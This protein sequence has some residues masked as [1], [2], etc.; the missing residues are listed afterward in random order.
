MATSA[1][2]WDAQWPGDDLTTARTL[3]LLEELSNERAQRMAEADARFAEAASF[4]P[5]QRS[6]NSGSD[7]LRLTIPRL[8]TRAV[9]PR[10][11]AWRSPRST[12]VGLARADH[13][14]LS[15]EEASSVRDPGSGAASGFDVDRRL[16]AQSER[17]HPRTLLSTS[18]W[19]VVTGTFPLG[20]SGVS[21]V[22]RPNGQGANIRARGSF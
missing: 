1:H 19:S 22:A 9:N 16:D 15:L 14:I 4:A 13:K 5:Q 20:A 8:E 18:T 12:Q 11:H 3:A 10:V 6:P 17:D 2:D 21:I 7:A